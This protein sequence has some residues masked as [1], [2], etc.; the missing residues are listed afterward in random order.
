VNEQEQTLEG[1]ISSL[2]SGQE[3]ITGPL[4][5]YDAMARGIKYNVGHRV[6]M[7]E[8]VLAN[9]DVDV[10]VL[11]MLPGLD[12]EAGYLGRNNPEVISA[13]SRASG[14][15]SL[16]PSIFQDEHRRTANLDLSWN[17]LDAGMSYVQSRQASDQARVSLERRRKVVQNIT[18]DVR[19]A[20][21]RAASAQMLNQQIAGLLARADD[22]VR[23]LEEEENKKSSQDVSAL[24]NLQK[25]LYD[26]MQNLMA[27]RDALATA[28]ADLAALIGVPPSTQFQLAGTEAEMMSASSLPRIATQRQDLEILALLIRPD[29]RE[30][31][32]L[33]RVAA[34]GS[35]VSVVETFPGIGGIVGYNYDSNS[36]LDDESWASFSVGLTQNLMNLFTLPV[37]LQHAENKEKLADLQRMAMV[38]AVLTQLSI[39][40]TRY[41]IAENNY[42]LLKRMMGVNTRL[43]EYTKSRPEKTAIGDGLLLAA[44]MDQLLTR[45]RLHIAYAEGQNA[46][47]RIVSTL[48]LDPLPPGLEDKPVPELARLIQARFES[49]DG[50]VIANLVEK[51]RER[52]NLLSLDGS[53]LP[54]LH[55]ARAVPASASNLD[56]RLE[57]ADNPV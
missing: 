50:D 33:K 32:L 7:V 31:A 13:R 35:T 51:I 8:E 17:M 49:L 29:M 48:G 28:H 47:G 10:K 44:E 18:Q 38:A 53:V 24:L 39:A 45:A 25:R 22:V 16:E 1:D 23:Q 57:K 37:R 15:Q 54:L 46:F 4:T 30:Q 3:P 27:Q 20:Y 21:W 2:Y 56:Q 42:G 9:S 36:F 19:A 5:L 26:S 6:A 34:R 43:I 14:N 55:P 41:E 11:G 52:T 12:L 40:D